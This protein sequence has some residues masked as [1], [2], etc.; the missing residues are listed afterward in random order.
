MTLKKP[1][2][3]GM[4]DGKLVIDMAEAE[5]LWSSMTQG[6]Q[7]EMMC[8]MFEPILEKATKMHRALQACDAVFE[9]LGYEPNSIARE[10]IAAALT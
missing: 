9:R 10:D 5:E 1:T 6:Q 2:N 8:I 7:Y 3:T 4:K